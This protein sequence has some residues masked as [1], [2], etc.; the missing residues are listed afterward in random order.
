MKRPA[1]KSS[2]ITISDDIPSDK[3][4]DEEIQANNIFTMIKSAVDEGKEKQVKDVLNR[5]YSEQWVDPGF[6]SDFTLFREPSTF[7]TYED[8]Q[9]T[10]DEVM[11]E[12]Q[13]REEGRG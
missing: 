7:L 8:W 3:Y 4:T 9:K 6:T 11:H 1:V 2:V 5:I 12:N 10:W 13:I